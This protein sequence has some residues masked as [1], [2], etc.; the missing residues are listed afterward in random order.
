MIDNI[1]FLNMHKLLIGYANVSSSSKKLLYRL[2]GHFILV[3]Q[4]S[5][6]TFELKD[7][8]AY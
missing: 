7:F 2:T 8:S 6:N 5:V 4:Y 1:L 3:K